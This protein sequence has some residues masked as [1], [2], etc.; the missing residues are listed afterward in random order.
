[1]LSWPGDISV[2]PLHGINVYVAQV[3]IE[4]TGLTPVEVALAV[5]RAIMCGQNERIKD[6]IAKYS[7]AYR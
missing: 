4:R 6:E 1:M 2:I 3:R 5:R 7:L